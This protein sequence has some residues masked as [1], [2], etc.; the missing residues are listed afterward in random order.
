MNVVKSQLE[1]LEKRVRELVKRNENY[2][3]RL[4][5]IE[6]QNIELK[7]ELIRLE[8]KLKKVEEE[9]ITIKIKNKLEKENPGEIKRKINEMVREIDKCIAYLNK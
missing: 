7:N 1:C 9:N 2:K 3:Q 8:N 5:L 6:S 4:N